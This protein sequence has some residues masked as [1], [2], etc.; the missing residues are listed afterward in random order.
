[1]AK[2]YD[3][4]I[5]TTT[6]GVASASLHSGEA[7]SSS[8]RSQ[9]ARN[10]HGRL[11]EEGTPPKKATAKKESDEEDEEG[12]EVNGKGSDECNVK[13]SET[14]KMRGPLRR[15]RRCPVVTLAMWR[16]R[17]FAGVDGGKNLA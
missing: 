15:S 1:M 16:K 4:A 13:G 7:Q 8:R 2:R 17:L 11:Q 10:R 5:S 9:G 12:A 14:V 6:K 3:L